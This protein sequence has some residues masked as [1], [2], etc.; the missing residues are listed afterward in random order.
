MRWRALWF[1]VLAAGCGRS[2]MLGG[3]GVAGRRDLGCSGARCGDLGDMGGFTQAMDGVGERARARAD[4]DDDLVQ[5]SHFFDHRTLHGLSHS[6]GSETRKV[7]P[8]P[9]PN[10]RSFRDPNFIR[11]RDCERNE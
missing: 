7:F 2:G 9:Q 10:R 3:D 11:G 4:S 1:A 5:H 8:Q 6:S